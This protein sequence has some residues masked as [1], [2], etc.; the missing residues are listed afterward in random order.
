[1]AVAIGT[2]VYNVDHLRVVARGKSH[3]AAQRD[4]ALNSDVRSLV[5]DTAG[6]TKAAA[7]AAGLNLTGF[8]SRFQNLLRRIWMQASLINPWNIKL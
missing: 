1:M 2:E 7:L 3:T 5:R 4:A 8:Q 6:A